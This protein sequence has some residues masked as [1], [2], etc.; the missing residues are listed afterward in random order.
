VQLV[1]YT[2]T[3]LSVLSVYQSANKTYV[4]MIQAGKLKLIAIYCSVYQI[5]LRTTHVHPTQCVL[6]VYC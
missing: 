3:I 1:L 4:T 2:Q 5:S 6:I